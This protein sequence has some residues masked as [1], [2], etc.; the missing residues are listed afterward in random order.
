MRRW[1]ASEASALAPGASQ[2][3]HLIVH[4]AYMKTCKISVDQLW[5]LDGQP[6]SDSRHGC[7][8]A[9]RA[10]LRFSGP[11]GSLPVTLSRLSEAF[12]TV[13][14]IDLRCSRGLQATVH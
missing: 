11:P 7:G 14:P 2:G 12:R 5:V 8:R 6:A 13:D 4:I 10:R 9:S 3:L 1:V